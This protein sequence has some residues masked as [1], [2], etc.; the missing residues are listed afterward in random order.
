MNTVIREQVLY[1]PAGQSLNLPLQ[2]NER[3][4]GVQRAEF[5]Y[6]HVFTSIEPPARPNPLTS[7]DIPT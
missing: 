3:V 6:V 5:G 1:L 2:P 4:V 7:G